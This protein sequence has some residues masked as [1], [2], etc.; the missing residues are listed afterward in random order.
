MKVSATLIVLLGFFL[1]AAQAA[2]ELKMDLPDWEKTPVEDRNLGHGVHMLESFG[3]NIGVLADE[4]GVLLIDAEWPQLNAK[5][6]AVVAH[7]SSKPVRY[8]V[9]TH[10]HWDH[11]GGDADFARR[12]ALIISSKQ[13]RDYIV[14]AQRT[15]PANSDQYARD[16]V[17][18]PA[19]TLDTGALHVAGQTVE[20]I[21]AP[22][23]HTDGDLIVRFVDADVLQTGDTF[24]HGFYPDIDIEHGGTID[25]MIAFY[26]KLYSL[27]GP[28]TKVIPGH[29]PIANRED[30]RTYQTML[31]AVRDRVARA[32]AA[33]MSEQALIASHPLDDLDKVWGGN[34]VKQPYLL[35]IVY[36]DLKSKE[37]SG[38]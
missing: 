9:N 12:G 17:A 23:A 10:W 14:E 7:I 34:L 27:C 28:H 22:P 30:I 26:D 20:I 2:P 24:F 15:S 13:T 31:R 21:H 3:G 19:F 16:P 4:H 36:E 38:H 18:V 37:M 33:G 8:V 35:A 5:V 6:R 1:G 32:I 11:V 25:G 29:G